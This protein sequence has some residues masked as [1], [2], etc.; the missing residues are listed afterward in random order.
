MAKA[1]KKSTGT[2]KAVKKGGKKQASTKGTFNTYI[3]RVLKGGKNPNLALSGT[4][5]KIVNSF[6][7]DMFD[8]IATQAAALSRLTKK[9]TLG[10]RE[11]QTAVRLLVPGELASH[12][13]SEA[14]KS[15]AAASKA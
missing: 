4:A 7:L 14:A 11:V 3:K 1:A 9:A 13:M 6:V 15:V 8:K 10:S 5:V 12:C 2:K